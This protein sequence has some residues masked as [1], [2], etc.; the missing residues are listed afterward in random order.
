MHKRPLKWQHLWGYDV[1]VGSA[2]FNF[3]LPA[4]H[5]GLV[6]PEA[7]VNVYVHSVTVFCLFR[8]WHSWYCCVVRMTEEASSSVVCPSSF[9]N[10]KPA[11]CTLE[12]ANFSQFLKR[13]SLFNSEQI[14]FSSR[15]LW[16]WPIWRMGNSIYLFIYLK[17]LHLKVLSY[18]IMYLKFN[19]FSLN[20]N[21]LF[22]ENQYY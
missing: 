22:C 21:T 12:K 6:P 13:D 19:V 18:C 8:K 20:M 16:M 9:A 1:Q 5:H 3:T 7:T 15:S 11:C 10:I 4:R 2:A 17:V 14:H